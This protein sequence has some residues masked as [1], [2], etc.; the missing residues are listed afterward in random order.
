MTMEY[1]TMSKEY[2]DELGEKYVGCMNEIKLRIDVI[3]GFLENKWNAHYLVSTAECTA[4]QFR[5]ILELVALASLVANREEYAKQRTS[6][7]TDWKANKIIKDLEKVNPWFY[8]NPTKPERLANG[9][10]S[11]LRQKSESDG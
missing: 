9:D 2:L 8:P 4:L 11:S 6:F 7:R 1:N 5:K 3:Q 10:V